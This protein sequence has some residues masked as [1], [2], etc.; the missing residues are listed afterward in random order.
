MDILNFNIIDQMIKR[1]NENTVKKPPKQIIRQKTIRTSSIGPYS[2]KLYSPNRRGSQK[3]SNPNK[4]NISERTDLDKIHKANCKL[5][6]IYSSNTPSHQKR[7]SILVKEDKLYTLIDEYLGEIPLKKPI[8]KLKH[9][10][11]IDLKNNKK[12]Q[13]LQKFEKDVHSFLGQEY[14]SYQNDMTKNLKIEK[15]HS[16]QQKKHRVDND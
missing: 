1:P 8:P 11:T 13:K 3:P 16:E 5:P 9:L 10:R 6:D 15:L 14:I 7:N 12:V 2:Q 4:G